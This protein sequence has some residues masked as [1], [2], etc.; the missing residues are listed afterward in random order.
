MDGVI[1]QLF[2]VGQLHDVALVDDGDAV[3]DVPHDGQVVRDEQVGDAAFLLQMAQQVEHLGAD[4]HIQCRDGLIGDDELR[5][6]DEGAGDADALA[7]AAGELVREAGGK[8]GQQA[9][10]QQCL[11]DFF[12]P[13]G[14][15]QVGPDVHQALADDVA[16]L[17]ALVQGGL[18]VLEDHLDLLDDLLVQ[19]VGDLAVDLLALVQDLAAG[20]GQDAH[21]G[22]ADG[23]LAGTGLAHQA[24]RLALVDLEIGAVHGAVGFF[25]GTIGHFE[26][27]D[28]QKRFTFL[29]HFTSPPLSAGGPPAAAPPWVPAGPAARSWPCGW[30]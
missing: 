17:G 23:G 25:A 18:R 4:G 19:R 16:H 11:A 27:F 22:T 15:G 3:R 14:S 13:L 6:H 29:C 7:L 30:G 24:E 21:D 9:D 26:V 12:F 20:S 1:H 2:G 5:L 10:I 8:F 28:L